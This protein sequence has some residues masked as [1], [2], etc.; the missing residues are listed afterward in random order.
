M[1]PVHFAIA[2]VRV[3]ARKPP[4]RS[5][6]RESKPPKSRAD[7]AFDPT[8]ETEP[9]RKL[10]GSHRSNLNHLPEAWRRDIRIDRRILHRVEDVVDRGA[11]LHAACLTELHRLGK[12]HV[13]L[14]R[15]RPRNRIACG[16]AKNLAWVA[17]IGSWLRVGCSVD[18]V[19]QR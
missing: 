3:P 16:I 18:T 15:S 12:R 17:H 13:V 7:F 4:A 14:N 19:V 1:R 10:E 11:N 6:R 8:S 9:R 2:S 5:T